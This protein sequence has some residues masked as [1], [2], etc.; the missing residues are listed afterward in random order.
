MLRVLLQVGLV[1]HLQAEGVLVVLVFQLGLL[2]AE[3]LSI[4]LLHGGTV[5]LPNEES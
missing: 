4:V 5:N 3:F 1:L 2:P